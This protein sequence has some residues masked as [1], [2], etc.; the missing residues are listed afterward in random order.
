MAFIGS[1]KPFPAVALLFIA[2]LSSASD[3]NPVE[4][5]RYPAC[6]RRRRRTAPRDPRGT[7][8]PSVA[9]TLKLWNFS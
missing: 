6:E 9:E 3:A 1:W 2:A 5:D 4:R 8:P 7:S